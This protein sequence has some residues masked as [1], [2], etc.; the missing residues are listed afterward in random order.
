MMVDYGVA[1][2]LSTMKSKIETRQYAVQPFWYGH[3][4]LIV[5]SKGA[6][7]ISGAVGFIAN[8]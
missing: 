3:I 5:C 6:A 7:G 4:L 8:P 2:R 1:T